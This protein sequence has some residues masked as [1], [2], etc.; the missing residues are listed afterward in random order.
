MKITDDQAFPSAAIR[1]IERLNAHNYDAFFVGGCVRDF[2]M[3]RPTHDYDITT[4]ALPHQIQE[5]FH[6]VCKVV[7]TGIKHGTLTLW[8]D[9]LPI[10]VTTYRI[11]KDYIDHRTPTKIEFIDD[12]ILDLSRRDFTIN[13]IAMHPSLGI[14]DPFQ[15]Q[16]DLK[17]KVIRCVG[18]PKE[19]LEED[20]LRILRALR[21]SATLRFS[22]DHALF[23]A[24]Q[25]LAPLLNF[26][27]KERIRDEVNRILESDQTHLL[28]FLQELQ[29]LPYLFP[30]LLPLI[31][32]KQETPW[33]L[34]DVFTHTDI[35]LDHSLHA[36][37]VQRLALIYHDC[38]K[39]LAKTFDDDGI[40][41]FKGHA[42]LSAQI[43]KKELMVLRYDKKTVET[44]TTLIRYHDTYVEPTTTDVRIFL[45]KINFDY[46]LAEQILSVQYADN[47]AKNPEKA[48]EKNKNIEIVWQL[49]QQMKA[50]HVRLTMKELAVNGHDLL[51]SNLKGK[52]IKEALDAA[53]EYAI[54]YPQENTKEKLLSYIQRQFS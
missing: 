25:E 24:I 26:L 29:L 8:M 23:S 36:P 49:M 12:L 6:D 15:G 54:R 53:Y 18:E 32:L 13:A 35:A 3:D 5:L 43:A 44:V 52:Q 37:L 30:S 19:R 22:L 11:E 27:S 48:I 4:N 38:G 17:A 33:H 31:H 46:S 42:D 16:T 21:F 7:P 14:I 10:E 9:D 20:A 41:H 34:F 51:A 28:R 2:L 40:A 1:V 39:A 45:S 47:C 50:A